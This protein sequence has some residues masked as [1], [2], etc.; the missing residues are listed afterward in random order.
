[1]KYLLLPEAAA[2]IQRLFDFLLERDPSAARRAMQ[3]LDGGLQRLLDNP[4]S[5]IAVEEAKPY[6]DL[7]LPFGKSAYVLRYRLDP[8][9]VPERVVVVRV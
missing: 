9:P 5:G 6:R 2:D 8:D 1:M 3:T 7:F 4:Y